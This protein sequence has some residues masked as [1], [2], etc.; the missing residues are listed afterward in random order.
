MHIRHCI[1]PIN[2][3]V[4]HGRGSI[5][6]WV[7]Y[8]QQKQNI[9]YFGFVFCVRSCLEQ[10]CSV[11]YQQNWDLNNG[12]LSISIILLSYY[13]LVNTANVINLL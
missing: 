5:M 8:N 3:V 7:D 2:S 10:F 9:L 12:A 13:G 1:L 6:P 4:M 11:F